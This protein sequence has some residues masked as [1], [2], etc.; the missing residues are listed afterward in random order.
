M[1]MVVNKHT[2]PEMYKKK[3]EEEADEEG[4]AAIRIYFQVGCV[5]NQRKRT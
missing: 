3:E 2:Q 1:G 5:A 4:M